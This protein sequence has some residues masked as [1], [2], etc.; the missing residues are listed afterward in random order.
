MIFGVFCV[1]A[2]FL[3]LFRLLFLLFFFL[4]VFYMFEDPGH[5]VTCDRKKNTRKKTKPKTRKKQQL[6]IIEM[7]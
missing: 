3:D 2:L 1:F 4:P 7:C 6:T 5:Q